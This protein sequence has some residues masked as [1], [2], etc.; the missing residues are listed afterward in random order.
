M[1]KASNNATVSYNHNN[2]TKPYK[3]LAYAPA[4][5]SCGMREKSSVGG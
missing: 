3:L 4:V 5:C 1:P 2:Y